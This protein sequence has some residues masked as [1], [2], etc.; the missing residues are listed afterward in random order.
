MKFHRFMAIN[1]YSNIYINMS[2]IINI[3]VGSLAAYVLAPTAR[4]QESHHAAP[5]RGGT[6]AEEVLGDAE[7]GTTRGTGAASGVGVSENLGRRAA[8]GATDAVG[9]WGN[10]P[11]IYTWDL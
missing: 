1:E 10:P 5:N 9:I 8:P 6:A 2:C 7:G 3:Q 4:Q 11:G